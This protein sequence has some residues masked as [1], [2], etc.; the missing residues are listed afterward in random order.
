MKTSVNACHKHKSSFIIVEGPAGGSAEFFAKWLIAA[1]Q[2]N[3]FWEK[4]QKE[5]D[6]EER[7]ESICS[8]YLPDFARAAASTFMQLTK[9]ND[10]HLINLN[11]LEGLDFTMMYGMGFFVESEERYRTIIPKVMTKNRVRKAI[12]SLVD[13][14]DKKRRFHP[15]YLVNPISS[16]KALAYQDWIY[17]IEDPTNGSVF[18]NA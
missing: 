12:L 16:A 3:T 17:A 9:N 13:T 14:D 6:F 8:A 11:T 10:T 7:F 18:G 5:L 4:I 1:S 15:E 2:A